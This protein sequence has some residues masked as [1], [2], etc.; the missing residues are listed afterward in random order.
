MLQAPFKLDGIGAVF[1]VIAPGDFDVQRGGSAE[2]EDLA[3][4]VG[5][6]ERKVAAGETLRQG[7]TQFFH[8]VGGG[9]VVRFQADLDVTVLRADGAAAAVGHVDAA[10]RNAN[11]VD[12]GVQFFGRDNLA[13]PCFDAIERR[14][15]FFDARAQWQAHMQGQGT[16]IGGREKVL[17]QAR[18]QQERREYAGQEPDNE[19]LACTQ[20]QRQQ[21]MVGVA[22][23]GKVPLESLLK[24]QH[25]L[26]QRIARPQ[27]LFTLVVIDECIFRMMPRACLRPMWFEQIHRQRRHQGTR[28]NER[29]GHGKDHRQRH[30]P[31]QVTGDA[32]QQKH[33]HE[34]DADAQQRDESRADDLRGAVE[35]RGLH[36]LALLQVPVDVLDGHRGVVHQDAH[37][38]RQPAQCHHVEGL[39]T[40]GQQRD[41]RQH[42]Q[43]NRRGDDQGRAPTAEKQQD[44]RTGEQCGN[45]A[46]LGH[47]AHRLLD[48]HRG[49]AQQRGFQRRW[50]GFVDARQH[51]PDTVDDRKRGDAAVFQ[52]RHQH[53]AMAVDPHDIGLRW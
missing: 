3:A 45:D 8:I 46:F 47:A 37:R 28:E 9:R 5:G 19:A 43:G 10:E 32:L 2:V 35:N 14:G 39:P 23:I 12:D 30:W 51:L 52:R 20:R 50:Q 44:H 24:I 11:I 27:V 53:G 22:D 25:R 13:N 31:E 41:G 7:F 18:Q 38:Q 17:A 42:C 48:E 36:R 33:R 26:Q 40:D 34:H 16:R 6:Q 4:D 15:T 21:A 49:I 29:T 1:R